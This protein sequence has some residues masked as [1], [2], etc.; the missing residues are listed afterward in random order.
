MKKYVRNLMLAGAAAIGL[1]NL[2]SAYRMI[3]TP[4]IIETKQVEGIEL[5]T[6][7]TISKHP[8]LKPL[9]EILLDRSGSNY[10]EIVNGKIRCHVNLSSIEM[11]VDH[12]LE[13]YRDCGKER[14]GFRDTLIY[15]ISQR[16]GCK[17]PNELREVLI[18]ELRKATEVHEEYG[19]GKHPEYI[20]APP[21]ADQTRFRTR[22]ETIAYSEELKAYPHITLLILEEY[23][24]VGP[25]I[26]RDVAEDIFRRLKPYGTVW[27]LADKSNDDLSK[28]AQN[29]SI[30]EK[31]Q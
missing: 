13:S 16:R 17:T 10:T 26:Y 28:I 2:P 29:I 31:N 30:Y 22:S 27:Q 9:D 20:V 15:N 21:S 6:E 3:R 7:R 23:R 5:S 25:K 19:H 24:D 8:F 11:G 1:Y 12:I 18:D 14:C 4:E